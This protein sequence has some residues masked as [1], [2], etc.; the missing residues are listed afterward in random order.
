V[1]GT[2]G[3]PAVPPAPVMG[4]PPQAVPPAPAPALAPKKPYPGAPGA[5]PATG[6]SGYQGGATQQQAAL[7]PASRPRESGAGADWEPRAAVPRRPGAT[8]T[9]TGTSHQPRPQQQSAA[10]RP[11]PGGAGQQPRPRPQQQQ[12]PRD[13]YGRPAEPPQQDLSRSS[14]RNGG[15]PPRRPAAPT[16]AAPQQRGTMSRRPA[17]R[18]TRPPER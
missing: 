4:R 11:V 6:R 16:A 18:P 3:F 15:I 14:D 5:N 1:T 8:G 7:P 10:P 2:G 13:G 17:T 12:P 9:G